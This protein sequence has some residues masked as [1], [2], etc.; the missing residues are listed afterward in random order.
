MGADGVNSVFSFKLE[1]RKEFPAP[2]KDEEGEGPVLM[3]QYKIG[4]TRPSH[5]KSGDGTQIWPQIHQPARLR[6]LRQYSTV[7]PLI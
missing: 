1:V 5:S 3:P 2:L 6:T 4:S 7:I